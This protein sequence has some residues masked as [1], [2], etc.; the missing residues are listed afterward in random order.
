M[1]YV[2][3]KGC[4]LERNLRDIYTENS[5]STTAMMLLAL[6]GVEAIVY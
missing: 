5:V 1:W 3:K 6:E 2:G 4:P